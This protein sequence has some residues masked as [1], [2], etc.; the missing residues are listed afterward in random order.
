MALINQPIV[1]FKDKN[2]AR[3]EKIIRALA[4]TMV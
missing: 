4:K 1:L 3:K 2:N